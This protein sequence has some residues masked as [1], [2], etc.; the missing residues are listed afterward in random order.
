MLS[1]PGPAAGPGPGQV[2]TE[3]IGDSEVL[4]VIRLFKA[5]RPSMT[6]AAD[7]GRL[8]LVRS[9]PAAAGSRGPAR[10]PLATVCV[11][12]QI[13]FLNDTFV[14]RYLIEHSRP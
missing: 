5:L 7:P 2:A 14:S 11:S 6:T 1:T 13:N 3:L 12:G 10:S 8:G 9:L 4:V